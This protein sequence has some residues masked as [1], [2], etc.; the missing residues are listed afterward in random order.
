MNVNNNEKLNKSNKW[1]VLTP[2]GVHY[3]I[4]YPCNF[5][6]E[7]RFSEGSYFYEVSETDFK[8]MRTVGDFLRCKK[9]CLLV[10]EFANDAG[11]LVFRNRHDY[12]TMILRD[13][14]EDRVKKLPLDLRREPLSGM[15]GE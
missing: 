2:H 4:E 6:A 15:K 5:G 9:R 12:L 11:R 14:D 7:Y 3:I 1:T 10:A 13:I 8:E